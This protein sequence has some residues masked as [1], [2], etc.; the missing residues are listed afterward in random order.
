M[1]FEFGL[2]TESVTC[3]LMAQKCMFN[4]QNIDNVKYTAD[5]LLKQYEINL[6]YTNN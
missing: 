2:K 5:K 6:I 1:F 4:P 3:P